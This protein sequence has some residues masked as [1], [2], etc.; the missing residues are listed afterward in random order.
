MQI[1][2]RHHFTHV[3]IDFGYDDIEQVTTDE[4]RYYVT[5]EGKR[6]P[7]ITTCLGEYKKETLEKWRKRVGEEEANRI[8]TRAAGRGTQ[9]HDTIERY[10]KNR[11]PNPPN[12]WVAS[13]FK[14]VAPILDQKL[15]RIHGVE[16]RLYSDY[17]GCSG[18]SDCIGYWDGVP[19][20]IDWKTSVKE[21][22]EQWIEGYFMQGAFYSMAMQ[23]QTNIKMEQIVIVIAC[24]DLP[25]PQIFIDNRRKWIEPCIE[26]IRSYVETFPDRFDKGRSL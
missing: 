23:E 17:L 20:I 1:N 6:Y 26:V 25:E 13:N 24:D 16:R 15:D 12:P 3:P 14:Q 11:E 19:S 21:K 18:T 2:G 8:S 4:F 5:P 22:K 7:S 10:I 9:V